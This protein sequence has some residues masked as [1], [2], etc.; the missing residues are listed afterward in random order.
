MTSDQQHKIS[1]LI[2]KYNAIL[3]NSMR[4]AVAED[5]INL[6]VLNRDDADFELSEFLKDKELYY[7][8]ILK[9]FLRL[10]SSSVASQLRKMEDLVSPTFRKTKK[11]NKFSGKTSSKRR[12]R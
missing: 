12:M 4:L 11:P 5:F 6:I 9:E 3:L 10:N 8:F 7:Q 2:E 1:T